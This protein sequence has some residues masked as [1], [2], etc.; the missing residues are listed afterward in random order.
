MWD[1][2]RDYAAVASWVSM[3]GDSLRFQPEVVEPMRDVLRDRP[4]WAILHGAVADW[5]EHRANEE[6][7]RWGEWMAEAAYHRF[8]RDGEGAVG[9][10]QQ[11][12]DRGWAVGRMDWLRRLLEAA[13]RTADA[14]GVGAFVASDASG[15]AGEDVAACCP[16]GARE[17]RHRRVRNRPRSRSTSWTSA[18]RPQRTP[19]GPP[20]PGS[21]RVQ[22]PSTPAVV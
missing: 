17:H 16:S 14:A 15:A 5:F 8:Q 6:S 21:S 11:Q 12:L 9:W 3:E 2:L 4:A 19:A 18:P 1:T 20:R 10:W 7:A 22:S 13:P